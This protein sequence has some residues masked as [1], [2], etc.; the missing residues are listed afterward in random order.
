MT[1]LDKQQIYRK[2]QFGFYKFAF[3][4]TKLTNGEIIWLKK[5]FIAGQQH[6]CLNRYAVGHQ[7]FELKYETGPKI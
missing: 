6:G 1:N 5:Y 3:L 7:N 4:P 2:K